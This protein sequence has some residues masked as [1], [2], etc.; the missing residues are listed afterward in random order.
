MVALKADG[1][2]WTWGQN[3]NGELGN[4]ISS[5]IG[6]SVPIQVSGLSN[7]I[8]VSGGDCHTAALKSD[9]TVWAWGCN[10]NSKGVGNF[11]LGDGTNIERHTPVQVVGLSNV[12][13]IA[14]GYLHSAALRADGQGWFDAA[15]NARIVREAPLKPSSRM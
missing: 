1:T 9:G 10:N 12:I 3:G 8:A 6:L 11:E 2:V 13:A 7:M 14:A 4:G 15:Q 5:T